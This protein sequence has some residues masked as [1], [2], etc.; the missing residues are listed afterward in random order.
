M[1]L[2]GGALWWEVRRK[3]CQRVGKG[4][5]ARKPRAILTIGCYHSERSGPCLFALCLAGSAVV[6]LSQ[7][8]G[9]PGLLRIELT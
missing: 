1:K 4:A 9:M 7:R 8:I 5:L 3:G 2:K 6:S